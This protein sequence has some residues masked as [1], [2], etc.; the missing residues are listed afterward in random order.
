MATKMTRRELGQ[1]AAAAAWAGKVVAATP[2]VHQRAV[3]S[4]SEAEELNPVEWTLNRYR[5]APLQLTFRATTRAEAEQWQRQLRAKLTDLLGGFP[6]RTYLKAQTLDKRDLTG[7]TREKIWF[8]SEPGNGVILYLLLPAGSPV[9]HPTVICVP[10]HGRGVDD[11]VGIDENGKD[12]TGKPG[13][14]HDFAIQ[15]VEHGLAGVAIER[16]PSDIA[17]I[18]S[19]LLKDRVPRPV[20]Q[21]PDPLCFWG[22]Q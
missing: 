1:A 11:I 14:Q 21:W 5:S 6:E 17:E 20:N 18:R 2:Q 13:Y 22:K 16:S 15:A 9:P 8:E 3:Q 19:P 10:G 4:E 7:Y 12:R